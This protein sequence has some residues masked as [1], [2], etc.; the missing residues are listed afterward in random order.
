MKNIPA[1]TWLYQTSYFLLDNEKLT[2]MQQKPLLSV[3]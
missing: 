3:G 2:Q 1:G